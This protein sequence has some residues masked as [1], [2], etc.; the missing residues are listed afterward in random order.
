MGRR[1]GLQKAYR[2]GKR[3]TYGHSLVL[4]VLIQY[5]VLLRTGLGGGSSVKIR[6]MT[7]TQNFGMR[8]PL[9]AKSVTATARR[10][11]PIFKRLPRSTSRLVL[12]THSPT[13][14]SQPRQTFV[15]ES[16]KPTLVRVLFLGFTFFFSIS[17]K[18]R[19][20]YSHRSHAQTPSVRAS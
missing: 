5:S 20:V 6:E 19:S 3:N 12:L 15:A 2:N 1:V 10:R 13:G 18:Y 4:V 11:L 9:A 7:W 17:A 8:T 16:H 14:V